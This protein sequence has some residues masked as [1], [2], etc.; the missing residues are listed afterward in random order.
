MTIRVV[1]EPSLRGTTMGVV[2]VDGFFW[3]FSL[4]DAIRETHA[5]VESWKIPG[6]TAIPQGRYQVVLSWSP[7]FDR[8]LPELLKVP[9]FTG[10]RIH[11]GNTALDTEGC[12]LVG[13]QRS[14]VLLR[15]S[16]AA[17]DR[18]NAMLV[19]AEKRGE[20]NWIE[21]ENPR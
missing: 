11:P 12:I 5:P 19:S 4:E 18:L 13:I 17:S 1:R 9:G 8:V 16:K 20:L 3:A 6:V 14:E 15:D 2:F 10:V 7:R 21:L